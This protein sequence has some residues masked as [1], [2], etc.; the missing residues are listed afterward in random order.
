MKHIAIIGNPNVGKSTLFN[1]LTQGNSRTVNFPGSTVDVQV[2]DTKTGPHHLKIYDTPGLYG[3]T[4]LN[5]EERATFHLLFG[6]SPTD[7][8][9]VQGVILLLEAHQLDRKL[10]LF[11]Q[12]QEAGLPFIALVKSGA[13]VTAETLSSLSHYF[14]APFLFYSQAIANLDSLLTQLNALPERKH[15]KAPSTQIGNAYFEKQAQL[16]K[17]V[18]LLEQSAHPARQAQHIMDKIIFHP[19]WGGLIFLT[20]LL[21]IF[22]C[23]FL[24]SNPLLER[25]DML[26]TDLSQWL[27]I[28]MGSSL[29]S[30][31]LSKGILLA[32]GATVMF[33]PQIFLLYFF[34]GL[35][36]QSGYLARAAA[37]LDRPLQKLGLS[38]RAF[39]P[40]LSGFGC[41]IPAILSTRALSTYRERLVTMLV[42]PLLV[43][44]ARLPI[45]G[46]I[47]GFF[48]YGK[49]SLYLGAILTGL[50]VLSIFNVVVALLFL[51]KNMR[52]RS[53]SPFILE[54]PSFQWPRAREVVF[55]ALRQCK[56][57]VTGAAPMIFAFS[58]GIFALS[59]LPNYKEENEAKRFKTSYMA[60]VGKTIEPIFEP[61]GV[62]WRVGTGLLSSFVAREVFISTQALLFSPKDAE[63]AE[64]SLLKSFSQ[65]KKADGTPLFNT[66][67][68]LALLVFFVY[69]LQCFSTTVITARETRSWRIAALQLCTY[70]SLAYCLAVLTYQIISRIS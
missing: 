45:Y 51:K 57:Y 11:S 69:A 21:S 8:K 67:N 35:L 58:V 28:Q 64:Q 2:G 1:L 62:D 22:S 14:K 46:L 49:S 6:K 32:F 43:C 63:I 25:F 7:P 30:L 61:M 65:V 41:A 54:L 36:E 44:S 17:E 3:L 15:F 5:P 31:F 18:G 26:L 13:H 42:I 47:L 24:L 55:N 52:K 23:V 33:L 19:V 40:L 56:S 48:F 12:L 20:V 70:N 29:G 10:V 60:K 9:A 27:H 59:N 38:G 4:P 16:K 68:L 39:L 66:A 37:F 34:T 50:Y 53:A